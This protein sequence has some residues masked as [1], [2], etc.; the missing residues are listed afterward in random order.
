MKKPI[1]ILFI[2]AVCLVSATATIYFLKL[3]HYLSEDST[4]WE[5]EIRKIEARTGNLKKGGRTIIFIG[6]SS[7]TG[8]TD[9]AKDMAPLP[10]VNHGFGGSRIKDSTHYAPRLVGRYRPPIVV[11]YAGDN[12]IFFRDLLIKRSDSA[13]RCLEDFKTFSTAVHRNLPETHIFFI[14]IKPSPSRMKHWPQMDEANRLI[15]DYCTG[16]KRLGFIDIASRMLSADG[17]PERKYF[18]ADGLHLNREGYRLWTSIIKPVLEREYG[19]T[20]M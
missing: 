6:S 15:R 18:L 7:V 10:V 16:D 11:I 4:K 19:K 14:S 3:H 20:G 1:I 12:D 5:S 8:W 17:I 9:L 2:T 13:W